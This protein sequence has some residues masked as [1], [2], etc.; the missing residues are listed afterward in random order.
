VTVSNI[1]RNEA[2][3]ALSLARENWCH[4]GRM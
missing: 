2:D 3:R 1:Y 4:A